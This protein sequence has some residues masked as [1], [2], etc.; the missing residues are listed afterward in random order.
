MIEPA[1]EGGC[2]ISRV[3]RH[4][5]LMTVGGD[6]PNWSVKSNDDMTEVSYSSSLE[7]RHL[8]IRFCN[9]F[10]D[11]LTG[12]KVSDHCFRTS[13]KSTARTGIKTLKY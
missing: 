8:R 6:G 10:N 13:Q 1:L 12:R 7:H 11:L 2:V 5:P 3:G 9:V 4:V